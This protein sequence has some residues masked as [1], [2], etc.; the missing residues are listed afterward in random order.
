MAN[1]SSR[2][3]LIVGVVTV[4]M[5][6]LSS[7]V[8]THT[9]PFTGF[10]SRLEGML[11]GLTFIA[12]VIFVLLLNVGRLER[13]QD[14]WAL[15][16][17][18]ERSDGPGD[19]VQEM[20][21]AARR[22]WDDP[23]RPSVFVGEY[24]GRRVVMY[25]HPGSQENRRGR[26]L[27]SGAAV[28]V[29]EIGADLPLFEVERRPRSSGSKPVAF[30]QGGNKGPRDGVFVWCSDPDY[31]AA[32]TDLIL[33]RS[34]A[35]NTAPFMVALDGPRVVAWSRPS[36]KGRLLEAVCDIADA[37]SPEILDRFRVK[38]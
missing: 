21:C 7:L 17:G 15:A 5:V 6:V 29:A 16:H 10:P 18:L 22:R 26:M 38:R 19:L 1:P 25:S 27:L 35:L 37:I 3:R 34:R 24:R 30:S 2:P 8:V 20:S 32:V 9:A 33:D 36:Q 14:R 28:A 4:A 13:A 11:F 12:G 31:A 23:R